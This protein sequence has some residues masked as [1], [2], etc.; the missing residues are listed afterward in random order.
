LEIRHEIDR[1]LAVRGVE[2]RVAMEFDNTETIKRAVEIDAGVSLLPEPTVDR[3]VQA[4]ALVVRPLVACD[5][6]RPIG[7]IQRRGK[8]LGK[9]AERFMQ[10]LLKRPLSAG[11]SG[12]L[13]VPAMSPGGI[14]NP[15][16]SLQTVPAAFAAGSPLEAEDRVPLPASS[17][18]SQAAGRVAS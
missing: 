14:A 5:L 8:E 6:K 18:S 10:L 4:R 9:T 3:E 17:N 1:A 15:E 11:D 7:I 2:V 12:D 13:E 16:V